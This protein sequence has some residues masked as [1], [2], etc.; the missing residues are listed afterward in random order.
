[1]RWPPRQEAAATIDPSASSPR[2]QGAT[3]PDT[4]TPNRVVLGSDRPSRSELPLR[5][6]AH[7]SVPPWPFSRPSRRSPDAWQPRHRRAGTGR[8]GGRPPKCGIGP[9]DRRPRTAG[10]RTH[11]A[12]LLRVDKH[13]SRPT[14]EWRQCCLGRRAGASVDVASLSQFAQS[15]TRTPVQDC[16][17]CRGR[18]VSWRPARKASRHRGG[19]VRSSGGL[20]GQNCES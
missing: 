9:G 3:N 5:F 4:T 11:P 15:S 2:R 20:R 19:S 16:N 18:A 13:A 14:L 12:C 8:P 1:M 10:P 6:S 7:A 17:L